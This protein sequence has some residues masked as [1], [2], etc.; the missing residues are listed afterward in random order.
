MFITKIRKNKF[1]VIV[2][3]IAF[4]ISIIWSIY[5]LKNFDNNKINFK[6]NWYNQLIYADIGHNW[7]MADDF[8]KKLH[9]EEGFFESLPIYEKYFLPVIIVGYYY[10]IIDKEIYVS[11]PNEQ[12]VIKIDNKK[13][14]LL[15]IQIV[16]FYS[17]VIFL[18]FQLKKKID[19]LLYKLIIFFL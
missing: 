9:D 19:P 7:S 1:E 12:K 10:H 4:L 17:S 18:A 13:F 5:N 8:R 16:F 2:V 6:G 3:I 15:L 11:K 14:G